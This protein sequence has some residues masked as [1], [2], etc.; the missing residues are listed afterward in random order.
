M[1][2]K[3]HSLLLV[4]KSNRLCGGEV[5]SNREEF[6]SH[7]I[8][9]LISYLVELVCDANR[10][11]IEFLNFVIRYLEEWW[12]HSSLETA[13][14]GNTFKGV[15]GSLNWINLEDLFGHFLDNGDSGGFSNQLYTVKGLNVKTYKKVK[16]MFKGKEMLLEIYICKLFCNEIVDDNSIFNIACITR[17]NFN[18]NEKN[19]L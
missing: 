13:P 5:T 7:R 11:V 19:P 6:L 12:E 8:A 10:L 16:W 14:S 4:I 3:T 2:Q 1:N 17:K 9:F 18:K 15:E